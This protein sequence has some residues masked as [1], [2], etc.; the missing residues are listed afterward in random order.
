MSHLFDTL[1][2][3]VSEATSFWS[4]GNAVFAANAEDFPVSI[5][6]KHLSWTADLDT[7]Q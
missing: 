1:Y 2:I 4:L 6:R 3:M 7:T 5:N